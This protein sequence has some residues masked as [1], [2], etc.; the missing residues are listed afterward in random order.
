MYLLVYARR[1]PF[2]GYIIKHHAA[3]SLHKQYP[4]VSSY[5]KDIRFKLFGHKSRF[6]EITRLK[7]GKIVPKIV[8]FMD[9]SVTEDYENMNQIDDSY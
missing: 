9:L 7:Y 2:V 3:I 1:Y 5:Q 8:V 6:S 4:R